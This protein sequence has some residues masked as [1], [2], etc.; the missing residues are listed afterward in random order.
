MKQRAE[1]KQSPPSGC[2]DRSCGVNTRMNPNIAFFPTDDSRL[3]PHRTWYHHAL[4]NDPDLASAYREL[5]GLTANA[6][7]PR[8]AA[9]CHHLTSDILTAR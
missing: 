7:L 4:R 5:T 9:L 8:D 1:D 2:T 6:Q 3:L